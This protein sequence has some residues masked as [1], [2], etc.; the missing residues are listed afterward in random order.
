MTGQP[1]VPAGHD[2]GGQ[3]APY[4]RPSLRRR[5]LED[6]EP[7][8]ARRGMTPRTGD[9]DGTY[10]A[11]PAIPGVPESVVAVCCSECVNVE[12]GGRS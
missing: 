12:D 6:T 3:F 8:R 2:G 5:A 4:R 1:R 9:G 10:W 11:G 7:V